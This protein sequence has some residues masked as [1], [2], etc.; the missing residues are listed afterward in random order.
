MRIPFFDY[1]RLYT[2]ERDE[3][4]KIF[5]SVSAS[6]SFIMQKEL[7]NFEHNLAT[8]N[9]CNYSIGV[10]NA[11]DGL[12]LITNSIGLKKGDEIICSSHTMLATASSIKLAGATPVPVD[13]GH[14]N[15]IDP[16]AIEN[17]INKNTVGIMPTQLNGRT[18]DMESIQNI[19]D[20]YK[21]F[22]I[23]DSAQALG[24]KFKGQFAGTFGYAGVFS[25]YPAKTLGS[26]GDAGAVVTNKVELFEKIYQMHDHGR[27]INGEVKSWGRNSRLDNLQAAILDYKLKAYDEVIMRRRDIARI[28]NENLKSIHQ[29]KLPP[30]PDSD[31]NHFDI[32]QNYEIEAKNRN[33]LKE[34]LF[35]N[36]IGTL[37][38]WGGK[39]IHQWENLGFNIKLPNTER[40]F[41]KCIMLPMNI[42]LTN[43]DVFYICEK[44]KN[45]YL[46][47]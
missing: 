11:T 9:K 25:F 39:G 13:I 23:E 21:L 44:I 36:E 14:D 47:N 22:I 3:L 38:Q 5:D 8:Y 10:A 19:A 27:D 30:S 43:N 45:F 33:N 20:K 32:Y 24:S 6:G 34:Y 35:Q 1:K 29:I 28:Y 26:F 17:A 42:F 31:I 4:L 37:I 18:C 2:D 41:E 40:F 16:K 7:K 46:K 15:L 12:E